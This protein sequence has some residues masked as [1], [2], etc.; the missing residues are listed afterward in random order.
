MKAH[1]MSS[2]HQEVSIPAS[3]S[4]VYRTLIDSDDFA[5][6][7]GAP[8]SGGT[9]EGGAFSGFGGYVTG[10]HVELVPGKRIVQAWR[11]KAWPEGQYS[12]VR[13]ELHPEGQG[14]KLVFDHQGFPED[15]KEHL[16][17]GWH[18]MYW[19]KIASYVG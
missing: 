14:T 1:T 5:A 10:R 7:T 16:A 6:A 19:A 13:F 15:A 4:R 11:A 2:I 12:I 3:P 8:A 9:E 18:A 17:Q